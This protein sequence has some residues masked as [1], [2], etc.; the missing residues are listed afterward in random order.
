M[1]IAVSVPIVP[2]RLLRCLLAGFG[3]ACLGV[4]AACGAVWLGPLSAPLAVMSLLMLAGLS[5]LSLL[6]RRVA[7][8]ASSWPRGQPTVRRIDLL[9]PG[10]L[11]LTVQQGMGPIRR[12]QV[13][14]LA[15]STLWPGLLV[16]RLQG[17][18]ET[19]PPFSLLLLT[20]SVPPGEFRRLAVAVR[21]RAARALS[22]W[23]PMAS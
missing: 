15:D 19:K 3:A 1:A 2:S 13:R 12:L 5:I 6:H 7:P 23:P 11:V 14:L 20:D 16:L 22:A 9:G 10:T 4:G 17:E 18:A 21:S 8:C